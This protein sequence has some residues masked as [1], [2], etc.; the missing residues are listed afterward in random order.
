MKNTKTIKTILFASLIAAIII[1]FST[2]NYVDAAK[3][4]NEKGR[5]IIK[6]VA[7]NSDIP[8]FETRKALLDQF[9]SIDNLSEKVKIKKQLDIVTSQIQSWHDERFDQEKYNA[10]VK[11]KLA[12]QQAD[13]VGKRTAQDQESLPWVSRGYDYTNNAL[14][15]RID[16]K[17]FTEENIPKYFEKIRSIVGDKVDVTIAPGEYKTIESCSSRSSGECEPIKGGVQ[18][19]ADDTNNGSVGFKVTYDGKTGF[20]TAGHVFID[21]SGSTTAGTKIEQS[22]TST[23]DMGDRIGMNISTGGSTWCDCAVVDET[24]WFRSMDDGVFDFSDPNST[25]SPYWNQLV[26][27]SGGY[28]DTQWGYVS[29][30]DVDY[31]LD[32]DNDD[33]Y[34][35]NVY[36]AIQAGYSSQGGDSGSPIISYSGKLVGMH[37]ANDG[38][39][40]KHSA[41][42]NSFPGLSWE[43]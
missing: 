13:K 4:D 6:T 27:I 15:I 20:V 37:V 31:L 7:R 35:T 38:T 8:M 32:L 36:D 9:N 14:E 28:S 11:A 26:A 3:I 23:S 39:F 24:S 40:M 43:F 16:S 21:K 19:Q 18:F 2:M 22:T 1:P 17:Y 30:T 5:D 41:L 42:T 34:E 12:L 33:I 25:E 10:F 29:D